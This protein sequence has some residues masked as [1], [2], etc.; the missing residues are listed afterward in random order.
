[1][2]KEYLSV[3]QFKKYAVDDITFT[4]NHAFN[5]EEKIAPEIEMDNDIIVNFDSKRAM[6]TLD[7]SMFKNS[8]GENHPFELEL[9]VIGFFDFDFNSERDKDDIKEFILKNGTAILF[10]Y[11]RAAITNITA[12]ANISPIILP[13]MNINKFI[14]RNKE[15]E[16]E[17]D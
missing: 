11:L 9:S 14:E 10:P 13:T 1:M 6:I 5:S 8:I 4:I 2:D 16:N 15:N 12:V 17:L 7:F 3:L